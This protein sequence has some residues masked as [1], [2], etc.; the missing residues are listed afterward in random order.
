MS[1][2]MIKEQPLLSICIPTYNRADVLDLVL[3]NIIENRGFD[4]SI[5]IVI[6]DNAST[7][8]T[9]EICKKYIDVFQNIK[10]F[11]NGKNVRDENFWLVLNRATG[12]YR[13]LQ[14]DYLGF[15]D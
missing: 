3:K 12:K 4:E 14:N 8:N 7:D 10:Y 5:E 11:R 15:T 6:S 1:E 2:E 9:F 13:K